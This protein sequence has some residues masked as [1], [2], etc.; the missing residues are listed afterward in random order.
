MGS[1]P[2]PLPRHKNYWSKAFIAAGIIGLLSAL[3]VL[4]SA[5]D[6]GENRLQLLGSLGVILSGFASLITG[7]KAEQQNRRD[8]A[9]FNKEAKLAAEEAAKAT[10]EAEKLRAH[11]TGRRLTIEQ[12]LGIEEAVK[13]VAREGETHVVLE[14]EQADYESQT[15]RD[16]IYIALT[17]AG[18]NC[19]RNPLP[20][21]M[22]FG[23]FVGNT[24]TP[25]GAAIA[26]A[27]K[28]S[29]LEMQQKAGYLHE[30]PLDFD[31]VHIYVGAKSPFYERPVVHKP[32]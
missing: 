12:I 10:L 13:T 14:C 17:R 11:I 8:I 4:F 21:A 27:I 1:T 3:V 18:F 29:G 19:M 26:S 15:L 7:V 20:R 9:S 23:V 30:R 24:E 16:D 6:F 28:S 22:N 25:Q 32:K 2:S 31:H 5:E